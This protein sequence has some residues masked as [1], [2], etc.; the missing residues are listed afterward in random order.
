MKLRT[1]TRVLG[2]VCLPPGP[3]LTAFAQD[4][5]AFQQY[6]HLERSL[7]I[8][9]D[10]TPYGKSS[11]TARERKGSFV[12]RAPGP[13][14]DRSTNSQRS[15]AAMRLF[16]GVLAMISLL[17]ARLSAYEPPE[18][19]SVSVSRPF[20]NPSLGQKV[21]ISVA[22]AH[23]GSLTVQLL[24]RDGYAVRKLVS[25]R[26]AEKGKFSCD[27]DGR[28][29]KGETV[30]DEA[31]SLK[32][33]FAVGGKISTYFPAISPEEELDVKS[34]YYDRRSAVLSYN[35]PRPGRVHM[36]AGIAK[37]NPATKLT[38]GP[39]LK[40]LVNREPR[41]AGAIVENWNGLDEGGTFYVPDLP[42]FVVSIAV[43]SLP[44]NSIITTGNR[45][46]TF[47]EGAVLREGSSFLPPSGS[48]HAHHRGLTALEDTAPNLK[49]QPLD[50]AWSA[51]DRAWYL[52][53]KRMRVSVALQGPS[54]SAFE[55]EPTKLYV[56][57]DSSRVLGVP[58]PR[59]GMV[60]VPLPR[61]SPGPH[62]VAINWASAYGPVTVDAF[63]IMGKPK[64]PQPASLKRVS[65]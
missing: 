21:Q 25:D 16:L 2:V 63:R 61:L 3:T 13:S 65:K 31:Y 46:K 35:L 59:R 15:S 23:G 20:F 40:T 33:D 32:V 60:E 19:T 9:Q 22:L 10:Q 62:V 30:P 51:A 11:R 41:P 47:L 7:P 42:N 24:D 64:S 4:A 14:R 48:G 34:N 38:E 58:G 26:K 18:I 53:G 1:T 54:A 55:R 12:A 37:T 44:E 52:T 45:T 39:V 56:F 57:L 29:E 8:R 27:W 43:T 36:Q 17:A 28:D 50:A 5:N 49:T 6:D